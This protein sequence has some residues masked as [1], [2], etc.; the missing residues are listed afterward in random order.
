LVAC[1]L[2]LRDTVE[3]LYND[4]KITAMP[5]GSTPVLEHFHTYDA[6]VYAVVAS[7]EGMRPAGFV[8]YM[9]GKSCRSHAAAQGV[10]IN[11][12]PTSYD[13]T[14]PSSGV[15]DHR[16]VTDGQAAATRSVLVNSQGFVDD[17]CQIMPI[18]IKQPLIWS[19]Y[20]GRIAGY[21][22]HLHH[23]ILDITNTFTRAQCE[24][25]GGQSETPFYTG[26]ST[27][28]LGGVPGALSGWGELYEVTA[29]PG[30]SS[31]GTDGVK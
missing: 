9:P 3:Q 13:L 4:N 19:S 20:R 24:L 26:Q 30:G 12:G 7:L 27:L 11:C 14:M 28:Y 2:N 15:I 17:N 31:T 25:P 10:P 8:Q 23:L 22:N 1:E 21:S 5:D 18:T 6:F 16:T 29:D